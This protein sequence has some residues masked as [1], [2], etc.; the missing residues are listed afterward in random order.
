MADKKLIS[1]VVPAYNEEL[2]IERTFSAIVEE[3]N[4]LTDRYDFEFLFIDDHSTDS[5]F[6]KLLHLSQ[7]DARLRVFRFQR[8]YGVQRAVHTGFVLANGDAAIL[9]DCDLQDPT[10]LI[11][12]FL[13]QWEKGY[14]IA[15]GVRRTR[16]EGWFINTTRRIFYWLIDK[17]SADELPRDAG[18]CRLIDRCVINELSKIHDTNIYVRGRIA[19]MGFSHTGVAYDRDAREFGKTSFTFLS[20]IGVAL[21]GIISHSVIPLRLATLL[22]FLL[23][24]AAFFGIGFFIIGKLLFGADWPVGYASLVVLLLFGMGLNGLFLGI[25]GEYLARMYSQ[26]KISSIP[27]FQVRV[28]E[29]KRVEEIIDMAQFQR[30]AALSS[31]PQT[32]SSP[33]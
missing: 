4:A 32:N 19:S 2:N 33:D 16:K 11:P 1:I 26:L 20:L 24:L 15:Y 27:V 10:L 14:K 29:G 5:T 12:L 30:N 28:V 31:P 13:E 22:G 6:E 3:T 25:I 8:N 18:D 17:L 9:L 23:M 7:T 21:D